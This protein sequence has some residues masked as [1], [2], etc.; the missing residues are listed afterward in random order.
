MNRAARCAVGLASAA[1]LAASPPSA[2]ASSEPVWIRASDCVRSSPLMIRASDVGMAGEGCLGDCLVPVI[3]VHEGQSGTNS[4]AEFDV[5]VPRGGSYRVWARLRGP[6]GLPESFIVTADSPGTGATAVRVG[7]GGA[8]GRA[9]HWSGSV[10]GSNTPPVGAV[11]TLDLEAGRR[12]LRVHVDHA[13]A[14]TFR[15]LRWQQAEPLFSP[16]IDVLCLTDDP[17]YVPTDDA[18]RAALGAKAFP[19]RAG[20]PRSARLPAVAGGH[21]LPDWMRCPRW[22]TKDSWREELVGRHPGDIAALVRHAAANGASAVRLSILWG[23]EVY[24]PSRVAPR[25]PGLGG[26]DYLR[27]AVDEARRCGIRIVA[28]I[29]PNC[30]WPGHPLFETVTLRDAGGTVTAAPAY[31]R[32]FPSA[33]YACI[34]HPAY[35]AF[36]RDVLAEIFT[37]Y[38]PDGLYVDGLTPH[39]CY[40]EHCRAAW[41]RHFGGDMPVDR[42]PATA[43]GWAVWGEFGGDPQPVGDVENRPEARRH[44]ELLY[45]SLTEVTRL[46]T[47][48]V[49]GCHPD[50]ITAYHSHP[51]P[52]TMAFYDATLTEVYSPRPWVHTSWRAGEL[53]GFSNVFPVPVLFNVYPHDCLTAAEA[54]YKAFQGL[55]AGAFP[56]F[57][58]TPGMRPVF[59]YMARNAACLDFATT[60]PVRFLALARDIRSDATRDATPAAPGVKYGTDRFLAPYVGAYSA[61]MRSALPVVT[62]H[63][64]RFHENLDGFRVLVLAN[65]SNLSEAQAG[66]VRRFVRE[67]GGLIATHETSLCD[68]RGRRRADFALAD[69][70]GARH[71]G[72]LPAAP[73]ALS[74]V[75]GAA[76]ALRVTPCATLHNEPLADVRPTTGRSAAVF[77]AAGTNEPCPAVVL[78]EFGRGRC[79]YL[80]GRLDAMQ[81][82]QPDAAVETLF[83]DAV[84]WAAGG[85]VPVEVKADGIVA[86]TL[87]RQPDR[88]VVHLVNHERDTKLATD[89]WREIGNV[90]VRLAVPDGRRVTGVR[91]LWAGAAI[92]PRVD[93]RWLTVDLGALGEYE[94]LAVDLDTPAAS[95]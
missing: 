67:G 52:D 81:C 16:G 32:Q 91:R 51:K 95:P 25:A 69:V 38:R 6:S 8:T 41:R 9:W 63:R 13:F 56:N 84:R 62:L 82:L 43:G 1:V 4:W 40:C 24:Y 57:W 36:L 48:T 92:E 93:G 90:R 49:K 3:A 78:N 35:R 15:P 26:L 21:A 20:V 22:Y 10:S 65:E 44:T 53:A 86:V 54:R 17:A 46:F 71:V 64:P 19:T 5:D 39:V 14:T 11:A 87:F 80:S 2:A 58:S 94:A 68:E 27:E 76:A 77:A 45:R 37:R 70:F 28:Y 59:E 50:A 33:R 7:C 74:P 66:A 12:T 30:L 55:A 42:L 88:L 61:L 60:A 79:V 18:A 83:A 47:E 31:G 75:A 85:E 23:G 73:R 29:N 34:N 72:T 89:A